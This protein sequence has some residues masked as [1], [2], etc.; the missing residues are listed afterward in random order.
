MGE[1]RS[2]HFRILLFFVFTVSI[3]LLFTSPHT[4]SNFD[5]VPDSLEYALGALRLSSGESYSLVLEGDLHPPRYAPWFSVLALAPI[6]ILFGPELGNVIFPITFFAIVGVLV[7]F[8]IGYRFCGALGGIFAASLVLIV[9]EYRYYSSHVLTDVPAAALYLSTFL[10]WLL[11]SKEKTDQFKMFMAIGFCIAAAS[12]F[13]IINI[14]LLT[15]VILIILP[16]AFRSGAKST[17]ALIIP[18]LL[19]VAVTLYYNSITFGSALR[20][21]YHYWT[22]VPYDYLELLLSGSYL[23]S[24][25]TILLTESLLAAFVLVLIGVPFVNRGLLKH[26]KQALVSNEL[27]NRIIFAAAL[28]ILPVVIFY[29]FYFYTSTR[30]HLPVLV[31]TGCLAGAFIGGS[32]TK[33]LPSKRYQTLSVILVLV[34]L[35]VL[36]ATTSHQ[37]R[38]TRN[39]ISHIN[40]NVPNGSVVISGQNPAY[41]YHALDKGKELSLLPVSRAVEYAS[42][43]IVKERIE[44]PNPYPKKFNDH[45]ARGLLNAGAVEAISKTAIENGEINNE[46]IESRKRVFLEKSQILPVEIE[47]FKNNYKL[48]EYSEF[49]LELQRS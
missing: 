36:Y 5:I 45:R 15:P 37:S 2:A 24:N 43:I 16:K 31:I 10:G 30:F 38:N 12:A 1:G 11:L 41:L 39:V 26:G 27:F 14:A 20:T 7:S 28:F 25:L 17:C 13:R 49:L 42:K 34:Y 40:E 9:P 35:S 29:S 33:L 32:L 4:A 46:I 21:G 6:Y 48:Y 23:A 8:C 44:A 22:A 3:L 19:A 47:L 18:A